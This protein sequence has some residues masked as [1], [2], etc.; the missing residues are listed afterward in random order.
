MSY[1]TETHKR[2]HTHANLHLHTHLHLFADRYL[3]R[4]LRSDTQAKLFM[5]RAW[6]QR[7]CVR[8]DAL[9][10]LG[11]A[12]IERLVRCFRKHDANQVPCMHTNASHAC[13]CM[14]ERS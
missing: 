13:V 14:H 1:R 12:Q 8:G 6:A 4:A 10:A 9:A 2:L 5:R 11:D 3:G 7:E